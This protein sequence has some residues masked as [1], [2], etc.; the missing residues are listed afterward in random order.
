VRWRTTAGLA[1]LLLGLGTFYYVYEIRQAPERERALSAKARLWKDLEAKDVEEIVITKGA[2]RIHL[3]RV[4]DAWMLTA[5]VQAAAERRAAEDLA[6]TLA[7]LRVEREIEANPQK[8]ADFGLD[9]PAATVTFKAKGQERGVRL[10]SR[11]P[12]GIWAYAQ[13]TGAPAVILVTDGLLRDAEKPAGDFR[14]RTVLA[15]ERK[16]VRGLEVRNAAGQVVVAARVRAQGEWALTAPLAARAD[17]EAVTALFEKLRASR[18]KAFVT[19]AP[20]DLAEYGLDR[21]TRL[22][23]E[24]GED[25]ARATRVLRFGK[26]VPDQKG[27]YAQREAE[28]T[29]LLVEEELWKAVPASPTALRDKTVFAYDRGKVERVELE[30]PKGKMALAL[31]DGQWRITAPLAARADE[32]AVSELLWK[33]R[34]LRAREFVAEEAPRLGAYGLDAPRVR[35]SI[36]EREAKEPRTLLLAPGRG[37]DR[38]YAAVAAPGTRAPAVVT[39]DAKALEELARSVT[40]LRDRSLAA[41]FDTRDVARI[42]IAR[43]GQ[44]LVLDRTGE[45][46]DAWALAAPRKGKARGGRVSELVWTL[47]GLRWRELV[48][49]DG[50][51]PARYGL[52]A[53]AAMVTL[54]DKSGKPLLALA[55]GKREG[56]R[57]YV[58]VPGQPA[59]YA[60]DTKS[61]G[62]LPATAEELLL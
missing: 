22:V 60:I 10:G 32:T 5:P 19:D 31:Q 26:A 37:P 16:D 57:T 28:P 1:V 35:V 25:K 7:T 41:P 38:A 11:N 13:Q 59:L 21:P 18:V 20:R 29:V 43:S 8:P 34:D 40:D 62:E 48:A 51:D 58:R 33:A 30:S 44:T 39:V 3:R 47:R 55:V 23:L 53:A 45:A 2:E 17:Q 42:T 14:D 54:A 12:T 24:I 49:E 52:D 36:W 56:E 15:I 50:W 4:Q 6:T 27:V 9:P 46:E 61:L